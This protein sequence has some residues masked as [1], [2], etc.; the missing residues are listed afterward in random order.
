M[1]RRGAD[2]YP[3]G[4]DC[5]GGAGAAAHRPRPPTTTARISKPARCPLSALLWPRRRD[6]AQRR[7]VREHRCMAV[8]PPVP[9]GR[10][11]SSVGC[12]LST[13]MSTARPRGCDGRSVDDSRAAFGSDPAHRA[14]DSGHPRPRPFRHPGALPAERSRVAGRPGGLARRRRGRLRRVGPARVA[15]GGQGS[16]ASGSARRSAS[17]RGRDARPQPPR[18]PTRRRTDPTAAPS[19]PPASDPDRRRRLPRQPNRPSP[20]RRTA[21]RVATRCRDRR[22]LRHDGS[23]RRAHEPPSGSRPGDDQL[24]RRRRAPIPAP[25]GRVGARGE[26]RTI[27]SSRRPAASSRRARSSGRPGRSDR[28][29][30]ALAAPAERRDEPAGLDLGDPGPAARAR[31]TALV[32]D[33]EEVADLGL[34]G[35]RHAVLQDRDRVGQRRSGGRVERVD[36]L[37]REARPLAER[38]QPRLVEDLVAVGVA[39]PGDERLVPKQVLELARDGAG[40]VRARRPASAPGRPRPSPDRARQGPGPVDRRRPGAGRSCPSGS[41]RDS[42]PRASRRRPAATTRHGSRPPRPAAPRARVPNPRTTAVFVGSLVPG[43]ASWNRPVSIGL[44]AISSRSRSINRNLPRRRMDSMRWPIRPASS[45]GVPR[46]ASGPGA[47]ADGHRA[48]GQGRVEGVGDHG[49]IGQFGHGGTIV[50]PRK[51]VLDS[52]GPERQDS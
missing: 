46:T 47:V 24:S 38:E 29:A 11:R 41:D 52:P 39:D 23:P 7:A 13:P 21:S 27:S 48:T 9:S 16:P 37:R 31:L 18:R 8:S 30:S 6:L 12:A 45:A 10:A 26:H 50:V 34:E 4:H 17:G 36:L 25:T 22:P 40:S 2:G 19:D 20:G 14:H 43:A 49:Q 51:P 3:S 42:G 33:R 1:R 28:L 32:V 35:R 15:I 44:H 5:R